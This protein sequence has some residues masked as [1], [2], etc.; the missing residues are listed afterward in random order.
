MIQGGKDKLISLVRITGITADNIDKS[1]M[2]H[3]HNPCPLSLV[4]CPL[5]LQSGRIGASPW[6]GTRDKGRLTK[7]GKD[8]T[9]RNDNP[10]AILKFHQHLAGQDFLSQDAT[11]ALGCDDPRSG[12][13]QLPLKIVIDI[14]LEPQATFQASTAT[15]NLGR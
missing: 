5:P 12:R 4:P 9:G 1:G 3:R 14:L 11:L 13:R 8:L 2:I 15:R 10:T 6:P 7:T